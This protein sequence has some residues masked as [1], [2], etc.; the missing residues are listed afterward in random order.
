MVNYPII[1]FQSWPHSVGIMSVE[2]T[3]NNDVW[4]LLSPYSVFETEKNV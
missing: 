2:Q 4:H 3:C 1:F